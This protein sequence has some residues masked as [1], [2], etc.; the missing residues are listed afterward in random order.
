MHRMD[1]I[2][3]TDRTWR[4]GMHVLEMSGKAELHGIKTTAVAAAP[5]F[6]TKTPF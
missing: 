2:A 5:A 6:E 3:R 1:E 4:Q